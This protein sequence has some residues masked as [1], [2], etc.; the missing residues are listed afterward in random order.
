PDLNVA[1]GAATCRAFAGDIG[2]ATRRGLMVMGDGVN[3]A[4]RL[5]ARARPHQ[6]LVDPLLASRV[7]DVRRGALA[8]FRAR[9]CPALGR[10][11]RSDDPP[12]DSASTGTAATAFLGA[13]GAFH[14]RSRERDALSRS[15]E[16]ARNGDGAVVE[17]VGEPGAGKSRLAA[18]LVGQC[19]E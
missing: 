8:G 4:A 13:P 15:L 11:S 1:A 9:G 14:G 16:R 3:L 10:P 6:L 17:I 5:A 18:E 19:G 7:P 12:A 2:N